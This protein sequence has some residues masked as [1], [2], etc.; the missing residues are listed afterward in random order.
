MLQ[1]D[2]YLFFGVTT[3]GYNYMHFMLLNKTLYSLDKL[4]SDSSIYDLPA[5][6]FTENISRQDDKYL[7]AI[8]DAATI[9]KQKQSLLANKNVSQAFKD[10][11][12]KMTKDDNN[13]VIRIKLK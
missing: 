8:I 7:Y 4:T 9:L 12:N 3:L 5:N 13:I 2:K 11:L 6:I 10:Y 1:H